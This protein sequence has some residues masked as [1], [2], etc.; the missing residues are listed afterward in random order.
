MA[1]CKLYLYSPKSEEDLRGDINQQLLLMFGFLCLDTPLFRLDDSLFL[2]LFI[3]L[4]FRDIGL[5]V[6]RCP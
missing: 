5:D 3:E 4:T 6:S 1:D 2:N